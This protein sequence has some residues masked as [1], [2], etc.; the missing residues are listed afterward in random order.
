MKAAWTIATLALVVALFTPA[1]MMTS[2]HEEILKKTNDQHASEFADM[3]KKLEG[4]RDTEK[5]AK[6]G[7]QGKLA[8]SGKKNDEQEAMLA[9][10]SMKID[11][12]S[13]EKGQLAA[14]S[15][16]LS[17]KQQE[18]MQQVDKLKRMQEAA[19]RR[20]AEF[21]RL[22]MKLKKMMDA[23]TLQVKPRNGLLV[24]RMAS[25]IVF[26][27]G[28]TRI[29][30]EAREALT[31]LAQT[32]ATFGDR[33]FQV[34]GHTDDRPI[35][36]ARFPS[37]WELSTARA[38]AVLKIL[39]ENGV[40]PEAISAAGSAEFDPLGPN[41]TAEERTENRRVEIV[42]LPKVDELPGFEEVLS[43]K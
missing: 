33:R 34:M 22:V 41:E 15:Q 36:S 21:R 28:A 16:E 25:D 23:G 26:A 27:P 6:E 19:E 4:E 37:N 11:R 5:V 39:V 18:L 35:H 10:M 29:K 9:S 12:L 2:T 13:G 42:F 30:E 14:K 38:V 24:V 32:L 7:C 8:A 20:N 1:C 3:K 17:T 43:G 40:K 31:E